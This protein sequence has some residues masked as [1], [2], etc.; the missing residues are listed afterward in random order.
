VILHAGSLSTFSSRQPGLDAASGLGWKEPFGYPKPVE[1]RHHPGMFQY[2]QN[3]FYI[4]IG[5][6]AISGNPRKFIGI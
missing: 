1:R 5:A 4:A 6:A 3:R 2:D